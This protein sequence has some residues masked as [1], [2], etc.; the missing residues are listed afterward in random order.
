MRMT[1]AELA[2]RADYCVTLILNGCRTSKPS[3]P[4]TAEDAEKPTA[5]VGAKR[6]STSTTD[7]AEGVENTGACNL[8]AVE[9]SLSH[10]R[11]DDLKRYS[12]LRQSDFR[13]A[14][15][16]MIRRRGSNAAVHATERALSLQTEGESDA[17]G[18]W[19]RVANEIVRIR[20]EDREL[21]AASLALFDPKG[22][23]KRAI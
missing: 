23:D 15:L 19:R 7:L 18:I 16:L 13:Q 11:L 4:A 12:V 14:A 21:Y 6:R 10:P 5:V 9:A 2:A 17:A 22:L 1:E 20:S 8:N 3:P